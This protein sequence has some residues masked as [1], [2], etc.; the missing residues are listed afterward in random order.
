MRLLQC[1]TTYSTR[2]GKSTNP[3]HRT[4]DGGRVAATNQEWCGPHRRPGCAMVFVLPKILPPI[5]GKGKETWIGRESGLSFRTQT[6]PRTHRA[7]SAGNGFRRLP[8]R[9]HTS[10]YFLPV[11]VFPYDT[12]QDLAGECGLWPC[13][14]L[15]V[16]P[17]KVKPVAGS[18]AR[19]ACCCSQCLILC[20]KVLKRRS[21]K[22]RFSGL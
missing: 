2:S 1:A 14:W 10:C 6:K 18:T 8:N 20:G 16:S 3:P 7:V 15:W 13:K 11:R 12:P 5:G 22:I 21:Y 9:V 19:S 17:A 4:L